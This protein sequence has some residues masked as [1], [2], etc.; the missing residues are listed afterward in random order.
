MSK[1]LLFIE[2]QDAVEEAISLRIKYLGTRR[3]AYATMTNIRRPALLNLARAV[4]EKGQITSY[5]G[6]QYGNV[7]I[8][9]KTRVWFQHEP[10]YKMKAYETSMDSLREFHVMFPEVFDLAE[11]VTL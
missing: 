6:E 9:I 2:I 3:L 1:L 4:G 8:V 7:S 11:G 5:V 10:E